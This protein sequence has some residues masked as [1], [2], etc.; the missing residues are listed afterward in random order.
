MILFETKRL[1]VRQYA[2]TDAGL[3]FSLNGDDEIMRY[4]RPA[5][6]RADSDHF[7][8]EVLQA[9]REYPLF[10]RWAVDE[11]ETGR[12]VGSFAIIPVIGMKEMQLGYSLLKQDWG[13]GFATELTEGGID[14]FFRVTDSERIYGITEAPN[15]A[16]QRVLLKA[17]FVFETSY[18][19]SDKELFRYILTRHMNK[20]HGSASS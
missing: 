19:E 18:P 10:G 13:R 2:S 11:R 7:F 5:K 6:S 16:S 8:R 1:R 12:F 17:G 15:I 20:Q 14:Y 4:I 3:F 9:Y